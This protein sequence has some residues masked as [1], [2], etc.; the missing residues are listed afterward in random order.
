[1]LEF[2]VLGSMVIHRDGNEIALSS[3]MLHRLLALLLCRP[4]AAWTAD[5]LIDQLWHENPPR[6]ARKTLQVYIHQLRHLLGESTRIRHENGRYRLLMAPGELDAEQFEAGVRNARTAL[7]GGDT[8]GAVEWWSRAQALWRG[9]VAFDG[10]DELPSVLAQR[11][12]LAEI[13]LEALADRLAAELDLGRHS[14]IIA[15]LAVLLDEHPYRERLHALYLLALYRDGRQAEALARYRTL[16]DRLDA[17]LGVEPSPELRELQQRLLSQ[18]PSLSRTES[19]RLRTLPRGIPGFVGRQDNLDRLTELASGP[20]G[21]IVVTAVA[22]MGGV[23]KTA[24]TLHWAHQHASLFPDGQLFLDLRGYDAL[25]PLPPAKALVT[26]LT[27]LGVAPDKIPLE[28][29]TAT[30]LY[31]S[32]IA[33]KRLLLVLDNAASAEQVRPLLPGGSGVTVIVTSRTALTGLVARDG[34]VLLHLGVLPP[35]ESLQLLLQM[36]GPE[37]E[38]SEL[39]RLAELCGHLPLALRIAGA[40]LAAKPWWPV[41]ALM[42]ELTEAGRVAG[43]RIEDDP[44]SAMAVVFEQSYRALPQSEQRLFHLLGLLPSAGFPAGAAAAVACLEEE[45]ATE[46]LQ[47]LAQAHLIT[48][49]EPGR[50]TMHDLLREYAYSLSERQEDIRERLSGVA[51]WFLRHAEAAD[52]RMAGQSPSS[53]LSGQEAAAWLATERAGL[54]GLVPVLAEH[55]LPQS[56]QLLDTL[57]AYLRERVPVELITAGG[58]ALAAAERAG[59][60]RAQVA[61]QLC[62]SSTLI[63]LNRTAQ[64]IEHARTAADLLDDLD[65]P[66][67]EVRTFRVLGEACLDDGQLAASADYFHRGLSAATALGDR[68]SAGMVHSQLSQ[69]AFI[70]G[71]LHET[72]E[73]HQQALALARE[74]GAVVGQATILINLASTRRL[75]GHPDLAL[76]LLEQAN[77]LLADLDHWVLEVAALATTALV[78][79][80]LGLLEPALESAQA[81]MALLPE[82]RINDEIRLRI[83]HILASVLVETGEL[84]QASEL[85][86][87]VLKEAAPLPLRH[88]EVDFMITSADVLRRRG[89]PGEA[90]ERARNALLMAET[91]DFALMAEQARTILAEALADLGERERAGALAAQAA[92]AQRR[93]GHR[94]GAE[95]AEHVVKTRVGGP[96]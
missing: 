41:S 59:D 52:S 72:I 26:L 14:R 45:V 30:T 10:I 39:V 28:P 62:Q 44:S 79:R 33:D 63:R 51:D 46:A 57:C 16:Y 21:A 84:H 37:R 7:E 2:G 36:V 50:F 23:G 1:M 35:A 96:G 13:R 48:E 66:E 87:E 74:M 93:L 43:L 34:G 40:M 82:K 29:D 31:R 68:L 65:W 42:D 55:D 77:P 58:V 70:R 69:I 27:V 78:Q 76:E 49:R 12:R 81:A 4:G 15:E 32:L 67:G 83:T 60:R 8:S 17:D 73:H 20:G 75:T 22:G 88:P 9:R 47:L 86:D 5:S 11:D 95:R 90:A 53:E 54:L 94:P 71:R 19:T 56:W 85:L 24:L 18:D 80:D 91:H 38:S 61:M 25:E 64:A 89:M 6:T 3:P 92:D